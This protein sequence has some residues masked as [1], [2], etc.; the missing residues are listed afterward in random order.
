MGT[1]CILGLMCDEEIVEM[2]EYQGIC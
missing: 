2:E 1:S